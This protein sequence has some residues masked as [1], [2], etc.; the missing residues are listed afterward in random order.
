MQYMISSL[1]YCLEDCHHIPTLLILFAKVALFSSVVMARCFLILYFILEFQGVAH[2][3][4]QN[5]F[6]LFRSY[7]LGYS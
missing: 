6:N 4:D 1:A 7:R 2:H 5:M 3:P